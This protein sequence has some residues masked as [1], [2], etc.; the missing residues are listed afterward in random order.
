MGGCVSLIRVAPAEEGASCNPV[1]RSEPR[2]PGSVWPSLRVLAW[3]CPGLLGSGLDRRLITLSAAAFKQEV[4]EGL[5]L[6][7]GEGQDVG[8]CCPG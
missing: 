6:T 3:E 7:W 1:P 5:G 4:G 2:P 8:S